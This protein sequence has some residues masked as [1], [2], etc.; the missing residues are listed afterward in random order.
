VR[1][2]CVETSTMT[3]LPLILAAALASASPAAPSAAQPVP[4]AAPAEAAP[5]PAVSPEVARAGAMLEIAIEKLRAGAPD[6]NAMEPDLAAAVKSQIGAVK[7]QL[8]QLGAVT[9]IDY[10]GPKGNAQQ[11]KVTFEKGATVWFIALSP[12]GKIQ[13]LVFRPA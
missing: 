8:A 7:D 12:A 5:A 10:V 4:A 1:A 9:A 2:Q 3:A 11:F 13:T 6:Y